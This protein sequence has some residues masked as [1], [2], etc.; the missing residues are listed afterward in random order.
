MKKLYTFVLFLLL[1]LS[2]HAQI[3]AYDDTFATSNC[4]GGFQVNVLVN[5]NGQP[6]TLNGVQADAGGNVIVTLVDNPYPWLIN[7]DENTGDVIIFNGSQ[8]GSYTFTYK[9]CDI[10]NPTNCDFGYFT[11]FVYGAPIDAVND[12]FNLNPIS[13]T[14]GGTAGNVLINDSVCGILAIPSQVTLNIISS[15]SGITLNYNGNIVIAAGTSPGAYVVNYSICEVLNPINCDAASALVVVTGSSNIIA[16]YDNFSASNY[17]N[18]TTASV[19]IND[20]LNG[21]PVNASQVTVTGLNLPPGFTLNAN[22]TISIGNVLEGTYYIPYQICDNSN[23]SS[24]YANYAYVVVFKNRILGTVR[25][26]AN[27]NGCDASDAL[28]NSISVKN[29]NGTSTYNSYTGYGGSGQYYLIGDFGINTVS[30][31]LPTYFTVSPVN[32]VFNFSTP[33]TTTAANFCVT[34]NTNVNDLEIILI[35]TRNV[36]PGLPVIYTIWYKNNGSTTLSAQITMQF[37]NAKMSFLS[38][39]PSP[40]STT[41]N[42]VTYTISNLAPFQSGLISNTKFS[43]FTPPTVNL[44]DIAT[45]TGTITPVATDATPLN[46]T[47]TIN[48]T[49]V[50]SQDPNDIVVHEGANITLNQ[51]QQ[52]YLHYTIRFQNVGTSDAINIKVVNDMDAKL[53]WSTFQL[54]NTSH[55]CRVKNKNGHNEFLFEGIN[56]PGTTNEPLSHGYISYKVKPIA[57]IAVGNVI[58]NT[59]NI[60]F[61]YNAPIATNTASTTVVNNLNTDAF[62]FNNFNYYPNPVKNSFTISNDKTINEIEIFSILGQKMMDKK[63]NDLQTELDLSE[64][65]NGVYFVKVTCDGQEKTLKVI[66]E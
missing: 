55:N 29:V 40:N 42:T 13:N 3:V 63:V 15:T 23:P 65:S 16:N 10:A 33:G 5:N 54:I 1:S 61:D 6:D 2:S 39:S 14:T 4:N 25:F 62:N 12:D 32:Q 27:N 41:A 20:T 51:A 18:T 11:I 28:L 26:D 34:T 49:A 7:F 59:A 43:V 8:A 36:I 22:G 53:D 35:P 44:G 17:P 64:F 9:I 56:L 46:N 47:N 31:N 48:Q 58:P 24:C 38:S 45:F 30:V 19:F 37:D 57:T 50:N 52:D 21:N 60:Y 66:K